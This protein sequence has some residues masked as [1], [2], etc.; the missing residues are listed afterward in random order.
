ML[1]RPRS[2]TAVLNRQLAE[3][4]KSMTYDQGREMHGDKMLTARID[5]PVY[6]AAS[7]S[8][9]QRGSNEHTNGLLRQ[10]RH[11]C[12]SKTNLGTI[13]ACAV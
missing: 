9:W 6:F 7:H 11:P 3:M 12:N 10:Y 13:A 8:P 5:A 1:S 2:K 4:R